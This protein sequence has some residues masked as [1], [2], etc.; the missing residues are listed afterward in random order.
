MAAL[1]LR[2]FLVF[3]LPNDDDD[4]GHFYSQIARNLL[5]HRGYSGEEEEPYVPTYVRVPGY[6]LFLAGVY[7]FFGRDN[8]TAVRIIQ[9]ILDTATCWLVALLALVWAPVKWE[10]EKR[11]RAGL[12]ALALAALCPFT[13]IY[14]T[15]ILTETWATFLVT[16][17]VLAAS[18]GLKFEPC[19][20]RTLWW[21][22]AGLLG[23]AFFRTD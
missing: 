7:A 17:F 19:I 12:I 10:R 23:G 15:T 16:G 22:A 13:A 6:P 9:S 3:Q 18:L 4:D 8:N 5:D 20:K 21:L 14:N 2:L 1:G 11:C